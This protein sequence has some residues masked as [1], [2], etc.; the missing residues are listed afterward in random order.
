MHSPLRHPAPRQPSRPTALRGFT[1]V[2]LLI[3]SVVSAVMMGLIA[4]LAVHQ[5]RISD[6]FYTTATLNRRFNVFSNLL[7]AEFKDACLLRGGANPSSTNCIPPATS[8]CGTLGGASTPATGSDLRMQIPVF[9]N[10][11]NAN[12][13]PTVR[14]YI[15]GTDL[16]R[17]GPAVNN[18]GSL[19]PVT[20][21]NNQLV[22]NNVSAFAVT[23]APDCAWATINLTLTLPG[24]A[25]TQTRTFRNYIGQ[26]SQF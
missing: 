13:Y 12:T 20:T 4:N 14:Y 25:T 21:T 22:M 6:N 15:S 5:T 8:D 19:N 7:R 1:L 18:D 9:N 17:D 3:S 16:R 10:A 26:A 24:T 11:T 2:E 23:V